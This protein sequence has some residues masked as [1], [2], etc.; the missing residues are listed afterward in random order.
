MST[1]FGAELEWKVFEIFLQSFRHHH[2]SHFIINAPPVYSSLAFVVIKKF[3]IQANKKLPKWFFSGNKNCC[4]PFV[5][6]YN[7]IY[8]PRVNDDEIMTF[9]NIILWVTHFVFSCGSRDFLTINS[10]R[11]HGSAGYLWKSWKFHDNRDEKISQFSTSFDLIHEFLFVIAG[12]SRA[13]CWLI[14]C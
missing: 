4:V 2:L 9:K 3:R 8:F 14:W 5:H 10:S 7:K 1:I 6:E 12:K 13:A 11:A